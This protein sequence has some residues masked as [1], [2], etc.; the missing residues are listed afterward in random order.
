MAFAQFAARSFTAISVQKNA[1]DCSGVYGLSNAK[2]WVFIGETSNIRARLL[3]HLSDTSTSLM[4]RN[5]TGFTF[6]ICSPAER[7]PRQAELVRELAP[8]CNRRSRR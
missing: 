6:E 1:P 7:T 4:L 2:E 3:E 5:P 8:Y